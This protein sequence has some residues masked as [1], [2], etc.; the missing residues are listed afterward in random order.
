MEIKLDWSKRAASPLQKELRME[1]MQ[2]LLDGKVLTIGRAYQELQQANP[3]V[4]LCYK[5]FQR[6]IK[7]MSKRKMLRTRQ[8]LS[9]RKGL[10]TIIRCT[11]KPGRQPILE[12]ARQAKNVRKYHLFTE[13]TELGR[14]F[15]KMWNSARRDGAQITLAKEFNLSIPTVYRIR[16]LLK[17]PD[18]H[19]GDHPGI[20]ARNKRMKSLYERGY[21]TIR[22]ASIFRMS[23]QLVNIVLK[24][25]GIKL[26]PQHCTN[27]L[28]F[29]VKNSKMAIN[30]LL[31]EI[32][33]MYEYKHMTA[34]QIAKHFGIDQGTVSTKLKAMGFQTLRQ[35]HQPVKGGYD[36][37][38][39]RKYMESVW[40]N[41]GPRKQ[42][43]CSHNCRNK[44]KD[45]R[46]MVDPARYSHTR[47]IMFTEFLKNTWGNQF[48]VAINR[49]ME[50]TNLK[51]GM[52]KDILNSMQGYAELQPEKYKKLEGKKDGIKREEDRAVEQATNR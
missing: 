40:Q 23:S 16:K 46:R 47:M 14:K 44:A 37:E 26:G 21:S 17:L 30:N 3:A 27:P 49:I 13:E 32:K 34:A 45:L 1:Y 25:Q 4:T 10:T 33:D 28:F 35:N 42:K 48:D 39:C 43:F 9:A 22:I 50:G 6:L 41:H 7:E 11:H 18:L 52:R 12:E 20:I 51:I 38:W 2:K 24:K 36:C 31:K 19:K 15:I 5:T 29:K 8:K